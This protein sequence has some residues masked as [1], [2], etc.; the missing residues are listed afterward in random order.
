MNCGLDNS[1]VSLHN[2]PVLITVWAIPRN[3]SLKYLVIKVLNELYTLIFY[4]E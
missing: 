4:V 2:V 1:T 3:F